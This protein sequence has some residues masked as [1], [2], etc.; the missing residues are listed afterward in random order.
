MMTGEQDI[1]QQVVD[2]QT[3][4]ELAKDNWLENKKEDAVKLLQRAKRELG[5]V[6]WRADLVRPDD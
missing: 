2:L 6:I 5:L 3:L 4:L 1:T